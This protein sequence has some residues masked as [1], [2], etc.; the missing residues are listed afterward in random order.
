[1]IFIGPVAKIYSISGKKCELNV[2]QEL[3]VVEIPEI[4]CKILKCGDF[5]YFLSKEVPI[6]YRIKN[7]SH[8]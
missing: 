5:S 2:E 6:M 7:N 3:L 1:M 4:G 8:E